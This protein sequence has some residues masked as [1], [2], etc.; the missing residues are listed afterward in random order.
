MDLALLI[1]VLVNILINAFEA[2]DAEN[3][4]RVSIDNDED[5]F[6]YSLM[7]RNPIAGICVPQVPYPF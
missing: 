6:T 3:E 7:K 5:R 4:V 2:S 1:S